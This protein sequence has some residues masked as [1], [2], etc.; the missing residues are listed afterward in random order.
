MP[1]G[2]LGH[3]GRCLSRENIMPHA[4]DDQIKFSDPRKDAIMDDKNKY[5]MNVNF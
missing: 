3:R 5:F 1:C 4:Q 2:Q